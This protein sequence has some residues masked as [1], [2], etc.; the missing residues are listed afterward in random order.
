MVVLVKDTQTLPSLL[1]TITYDQL[2]FLANS[3]ALINILIFF[4]KSVL[5]T[6]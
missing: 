3:Y 4:K 1:N 2:S 5:P 6:S